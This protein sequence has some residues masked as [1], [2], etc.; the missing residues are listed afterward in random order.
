[1]FK[2]LVTRLKGSVDFLN[3][4]GPFDFDAAIS[5]AERGMST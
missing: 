2:D 4:E 5:A 1:M 3:T